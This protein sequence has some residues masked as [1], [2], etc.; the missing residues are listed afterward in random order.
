MNSFLNRRTLLLFLGLVCSPGLISQEPVEVER[1]S[2]KVILEGKVYYI[3]VVKPGQ[4]LYSI[5]VAYNVSQKEITIE[6]PGA[7][8]GLQIGQAL[9]IPVEQTK[10]EKID[11]AEDIFPQDSLRMHTVQAGETVFSISQMY[12]LDTEDIM[13]ANPG[14]NIDDL[15]PGMKLVIPLDDE[16]EETEPVYNEEGFAYHRVKRRETLYSIS[17]FYDVP[18]EEIREANPELGWAGPKTGQVLR[19]PLHQVIDHPETVLDT[20]PPETIFQTEADTLPEEYHYEDL[21]QRHHDP[22]RVYRVAFFI[23]F[24]FREPEPLDS[25]IQDVRSATRRNRIIERYRMEQKDPQSVNF[26]EFF[27]GSLL[28]VDSLARTG[29]RMDLRFYDTRKSTDRTRSLLENNELENFDL[30]IGPFYP[31]NL[32]IVA[33]FSEIYRIPLVTPF[34]TDLELISFNP[35]LFQPVPSQETGFRQAA[36]LVAGKY[37]YNIVYVREEDSLNIDQHTH[38]KELIFDELDNVYSQEPV[39]FKEVVLNL[40]HSE[41]IIQ[42]LSPDKKNFVV[43]PTRNEALASRVVSSLYFSLKDYD[44]EMLGTPYWPEFSS[45]DYRY[46]HDLNLIFYHSHWID[47]LDPGIER[48]LSSYRRHF[49]NEPQARTM[50]GVNYGTAGFD[51]TFYFINALRLYGPRFMLSLDDYRP[52]LVNNGY[53]FSRVTPYGGFEN[54]H[55][56]FYQFTPEKNIEK[57]EVPEPPK[58]RF[59]F[60]PLEDRRRKYLDIDWE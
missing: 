52:D 4:T 15:Q 47:Y 12:D 14:I 50:R 43:F 18:V 26:L 34:H 23:P 2:N 24:D 17:R 16:K 38:F 44:I 56:D 7:I 54:D 42:S 51:L 3:H 37:A 30:F 21:R 48:F 27:E 46:Y 39:V 60:W 53:S 31:Y 36:K 11:T 35:F 9:K 58:R 25:L 10:D 40:T 6:N 57:I 32:E 5:A 22:D 45:I 8:S 20:V 41:K 55:I 59:F 28:A 29:M 49:Y 1:S 33:E 19:I 13:N